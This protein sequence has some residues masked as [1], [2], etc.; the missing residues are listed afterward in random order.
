MDQRKNNELN[1]DELEQVSGGDSRGVKSVS[2]TC[3]RC[4]QPFES[5]E[6]DKTATCPNCGE[7]VYKSRR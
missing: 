7:I 5:S 1:L 3:P 6:Y 2:V 4:Q